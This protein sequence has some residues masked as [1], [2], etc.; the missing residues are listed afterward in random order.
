MVSSPTKQKWAVTKLFLL[1]NSRVQATYRC[2]AE[3]ICW[4]CVK[5]GE[6]GV[7]GWATSESIFLEGSPLMTAATAPTPGSPLRSSQTGMQARNDE[8]TPARL[9]PR[10]RPVVGAVVAVSAPAPGP[11]PSPPQPAPVPLE[12]YGRGLS[13]NSAIGLQVCSCGAPF[14]DAATPFCRTCGSRRPDPSHSRATETECLTPSNAQQPLADALR[15][16]FKKQERQT[17]DFGPVI[18][19]GCGLT[20][21]KLGHTTGCCKG[22][23]KRWTDVVDKVAGYMETTP[24]LGWGAPVS[25]QRSTWLT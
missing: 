17:T 14:F 22:C 19:L 13:G 20:I 21:S 18:C 15:A 2:E 16:G 1:H 9:S 6:G 3:G 25:P 11:L 24:P 23:G 7:E 5:K 10:G 4:I 8:V 12:P